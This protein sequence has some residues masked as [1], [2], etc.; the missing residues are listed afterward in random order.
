MV[1]DVQIASSLPKASIQTSMMRSRNWN[2]INDTWQQMESNAK[3]VV[4]KNV[5]FVFFHKSIV[6][7][8]LFVS[9]KN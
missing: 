5:V 1:A 9:E 6:I 3:N 2:V 7:K 8:N 4:V